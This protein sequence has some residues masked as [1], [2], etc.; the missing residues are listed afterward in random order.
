ML[1]RVRALDTGSR[2]EVAIDEL[3]RWLPGIRSIR[4]EVKAEPGLRRSAPISDDSVTETWS[5]TEIGHLLSFGFLGDDSG[6]T[7]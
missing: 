5:P 2:T 7:H 1:R 6:E 4:H 3:E